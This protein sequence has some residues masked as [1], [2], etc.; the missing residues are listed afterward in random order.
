VPGRRASFSILLGLSMIGALAMILSSAPHGVSKIYQ[1]QFA[2]MAKEA[3]SLK[4][5]DWNIERGL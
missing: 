3:R 1:G 4:L 5:L 2:S